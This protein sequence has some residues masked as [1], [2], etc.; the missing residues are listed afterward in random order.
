VIGAAPT[1]F[2]EFGARGGGALYAQGFAPGA[3]PRVPAERTHVRLSASRLTENESTR[4]G[5]AVLGTRGALVECGR[6]GQP[7]ESPDVFARNVAHGY[8]GAIALLNA[9]L[10]IAAGERLEGN[11]ASLGDGGA[12]FVAGV[13][14]YA[15][16]P[17]PLELS[18]LNL[19]GLG[20]LWADPGTRLRIEGSAG[21]PVLFTGNQAQVGTFNGE[22]V[23]GQGGAIY[24]YQDRPLMENPN[25]AMVQLDRT[26]GLVRQVSIRHVRS[27]RDGGNEARDGLTGSA[28]ALHGLDHGWRDA[29]T[30]D[31]SRAARD[32]WIG[33]QPGGG[34]DLGPFALDGIDVAL[35][36]GAGVLEIDSAT[37]TDAGLVVGPSLTPTGDPWDPLVRIPGPRLVRQ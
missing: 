33:R 24:V 18:Q 5:G 34:L 16:L 37:V 1:A 6:I 12:L 28:I 2:G 21:D 13:S 15:R 19:F 11:R 27:E 31:A 32:T 20:P 29:F 9:S 10:E 36:Q 8:G 3:V 17:T 25:T 26:R 22:D 7:A 14:L 23:G 4:G 30:T 35:D